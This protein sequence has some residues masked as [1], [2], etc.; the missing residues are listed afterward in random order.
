M[1]I[2]E[3]SIFQKCDATD[4]MRVLNIYLATLF[5]LLLLS[6]VQLI[7]K[8]LV[9]LRCWNA[10]PT[11]TSNALV[12]NESINGHASHSSYMNSKM[13]TYEV[14]HNNTQ[15]LVVFFFVILSS[16]T[17]APFSPFRIKRK[18]LKLKTFWEPHG[19]TRFRLYRCKHMMWLIP[20][21]EDI[22]DSE[23]GGN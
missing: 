13:K 9:S 7:Q 17:C 4:D 1:W 16:K 22:W 8:W 23:F 20:E 15:L 21:L 19:I 18:E 10:G 11:F 3:N 2:S 5:L 6:V 12:T 14:Q